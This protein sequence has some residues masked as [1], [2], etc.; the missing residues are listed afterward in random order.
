MAVS[1]APRKFVDDLPRI[2]GLYTGGFIVFIGLMAILE[3]M[4]VMKVIHRVVH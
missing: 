2:Y 1:A 3:Q 4:G